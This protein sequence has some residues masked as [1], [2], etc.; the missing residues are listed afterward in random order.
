M[1][2]IMLLI[3]IYRLKEQHESINE[4]KKTNNS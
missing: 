1:I 4:N 3:S 2:Y